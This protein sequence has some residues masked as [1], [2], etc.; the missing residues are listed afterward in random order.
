MRNH[1]MDVIKGIGIIFVVVLHVGISS[2]VFTNFFNLFHMAIFFFS[3]GWCF[4]KKYLY[5]NGGGRKYVMR[6]IKT[7]Y[8]PYAVFN[9]IMIVLHNFLLK[10]NVYTD[11]EK[12]LAEN[13]GIGNA[14]GLQHRYTAETVVRKV[15]RILLGGV[16]G[17]PQL[18]G[19]T[20]FLRA[21]FIVSVV[22]FLIQ[23]AIVCMDALF[24]IRLNEMVIQWIAA[25]VLLL[26]GWYGADRGLQNKF[27]LLTCSSVYFVYVFGYSVRKFDLIGKLYLHAAA[28]FVIA[29]C[30][31]AGL[32]IMNKYGSIAVN[33][34][35]YTN[36]PFLIGASIA[37]SLLCLSIAVL[38]VRHC[39][40][41]M[42]LMSY[43]GRNSLSILLLHF[44][45]FK[46]V[47]LAEIL[48]YKKPGYLLAAFPVLFTDGIWRY[49]YILAGIGIPLGC[50][51][52]FQK[53]KTELNK[54]K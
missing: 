1:E 7:L 18:G 4:S 13:I 22:F 50:N 16:S 3:A 24:K 40:I 12:F 42:K 23:K 54:V 44:T 20:W 49:L 11:N 32:W 10:V 34:N 53:V 28:A 25:F 27:S 52:V 36:P 41:L 14:F 47:T 48:Y 29:C 8:V 30:M 2:F 9:S 35:Q 6:K 39:R 21:L 45:A 46:A 43:I 26:I 5:E 17:E 38:V 37:G 33:A 31:G 19:A 51:C 15:I